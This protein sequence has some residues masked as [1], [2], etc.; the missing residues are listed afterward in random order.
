MRA[1]VRTCLAVLAVAFFSVG[2]GGSGGGGGGGGGGN[3]PGSGTISIVS[4]TPT[5]L[6]GCAPTPITING[7]GFNSIGGTTF[8]VVFHAQGGATPFAGGS[9]DTATATG[10]VT[11]ATTMTVVVPPVVICDG[12]S[13]LT[14]TFDV[15]LESGVAASGSGSVSFT[16]AG[17]A[18]ASISTPTVPAAV[19]TPFVL[20]GTGFGPVGGAVTIRLTADGGATIFKDGTKPFADVQG[21]VASTTTI[22]GVTPI[23]TVCGAASAGCSVKLLFPDG[24]CT[25]TTA[26]GF[27]TFLAPTVTGFSTATLKAAVSDP[28]FVVNGTGFG[29]DGSVAQV[30]FVADGGL[31]LFHDATTPTVVVPG[32]VSGGGT[33]ITCASPLAA[34]CGAATRTASVQVVTAYGSSCAASAPGTLTFTAPTITGAAVG[35]PA[36]GSAPAQIDVTG[37][38]FGP[39]GAPTVV[40]FIADGGA[41]MFEDGTS[42]TIDVPAVVFSATAVRLTTPLVTV[43]GAANRKA[44]LRVFSPYGGACVDTG[45]SYVQFDGPTLALNGFAPNPILST[46]PATFT[47][48]GTNFGP[49]GSAASVRFVA[50][51]GATPFGNGSLS[52][53]TVVGTVASATQITGVAPTVAACGPATS[54]SVVVTLSDGSCVA[55]AAAYV[56]WSGPTLTAPSA[57]S[58]VVVLASAP[59][60][61]I[62]LTG[63]GFAPVGGVA[64][65][66]FV[67]DTAG[68]PLF[69]D[70][71]LFESAAV[72]GTIT[73]STAISVRPP[74]ATVCGATSRLASIRVELANG[75]CAATA[76]Q[77][78][79]YDGPSILTIAAVPPGPFLGGT[80]TPFQISGAGF[81]PVG[82]EAIVRF[83]ASAGAPFANGTAA[84][85]DVAGTV[86]SAS[87][88]TG[89][90]PL[91]ALCGVASVTA[92]FRVTLQDG[93]CADSAANAI[94]W[95]GPTIT[96]VGGVSPFGVPAAVPTV[97]TINGTGFGPVGSAVDVTFVSDAAGPALFGDGTLRESSVVQG[98][99]ASTTQITVRTPHAT[100]CEATSRLASVRIALP[101]GACASSPTGAIRFDAPTLTSL[102]AV[103]AGP[104]VGSVQTGFQLN[105]TNLGSVTTTPA[106]VRFVA[107]SGTPFANGT[108][109]FFDVPGV[110]NAAGTQITGT[111]P[112]VTL[113]G[114]ASVTGSVRVTLQDGTCVDSAASFFTFTGPTVT[115][116]NGVVPAVV[117][118]SSPAPITI[119]GTGF[120]PVGGFADVV[121][122]SDP[123]PEPPL[124]ADGTQ[125]ESAPVLGTI[126]SATTITVTPPNVTVSNAGSRFASVRVRLA[127]GSCAA[128]AAQ[129][130]RFDAPTIT[131]LVATPGPTL[132]A[133][134]P[135]GFTING[136]NFGPG[137]SEAL[138]RFVADGGATPFGNGTLREMTVAGT[139][140][141]GGTQ[142][143]GTTPLLALCPTASMGVAV[144]VMLQDGTS[145]Q[146]GP[147]FATFQAP[148]VTAFAP[149]TFDAAAPSPS[150]FTITGTGFG[151]VGSFVNVR[152]SATGG[153]RPFG[154]GTLPDI[155]VLGQVVSAT[156]VTGTL[157]LATVC[158]VPSVTATVT[159]NLTGGAC[160]STAAGAVTMNGPT[161]AV[162]TPLTPT[163][164]SSTTSSAFT[165]N[166]TGFGPVGQPAFVTFTALA[167]SPFGNGTLVETTVTGTIASATQ[168]TGFAPLA[169][170][171]TGTATARVTVR[172]PNGSCTPVAGAPV[173]T[174]TGPTITA[175][176]PVSVATAGL[177]PVTFTL[178]GTGFAP[179]GPVTVRF[180]S[181]DPIFGDATDLFADVVGTVVNATTITV[182]T[183]LARVCTTTNSA[184]ASARVLFANGSCADSP[185]AVVT[186]NGPTAASVT[187]LPP[188]PALNPGPVTINGTNYPPVGTPVEVVFTAVNG[189]PFATGTDREARVVG[190]VNP[191]G[192]ITVT[193]PL[194]DVCPPLP[195]IAATISLNFGS[196][197]CLTPVPGTVT[198]RAP[199]FT[200]LAVVT[201]AN[202]P[203]SFNITGIDFPVVGTI[204][205]VG[206][207]DNANPGTAFD[208][209]SQ[210]R[211]TVAGVVSALNTIT[212]PNPPRPAAC[213]AD[214][215]SSVD[216]TFG[217]FSCDYPVGGTVTFLAPTITSISQPTIATLT[218][219]NLVITGTNFGPTGVQ[220]LV[221]WQSADLIFADGNQ[222]AIDLPGTV[223]SNTTIAT[224]AP[225]ARIC[226]NTTSTAT[227]RV[228]FPQGS[229]ADSPNPF[230]TFP[231]PTFTANTPS[232]AALN[233]GSLTITGANFPPVGTPVTVHLVVTGTPTNPRIFGSGTDVETFAYGLVG[234]ANSVTVSLPTGS[235]CPPDAA[236]T[237]AARVT[238]ANGSCAEA[239]AATVTYN[240][241]TI[242]SIG[243]VTRDATEPANL[244][245]NGT[246]FPPVNTQVVVRFTAGAAYPQLFGNAGLTQ[247]VVG[248][249]TAA[250]SITVRPPAAAVCELT[251][252]TASLDVNFGND[253]CYYAVP[254]SF[255]YQGPAI[256]T[257]SPNTITALTPAAVTLT[258]VRFGPTVPAGTQ[259]TV[260]WTSADPIFG[261]GTL[262]SVDLPG[263]IASSTSIT[264][265]API[266]RVCAG[267]SSDASIRVIFPMGAC[268]T[269][270]SGSAGGGVTFQG[271]VVT[272]LAATVDAL[273]PGS[274][275]VTGTNFPPVGTPISVTLTAPAGQRPFASGTQNQATV[276][277]QVSPANTIAVV[278]PI[279]DVP[280]VSMVM[281]VGLDIGN[282]TCPSA[283]A[284]TVTYLAPVVA[285]I[286]APLLRDATAPASLNVTGT[287]FPAAGA[288]AEVRFTSTLPIFG[289]TSQTQTV[290]GTV[291]GAGTLTVTPPA[292]AVCE[293]A[294]A[295]ATLAVRFLG[296]SLF[297]AV[298]GTL[299]YQAPAVSSI[300]PA[301]VNAMTPQALTITGVRF[302][303]TAAPT[304]QV[305]VRWT[306]ADPIFGDGTLTSVDLPGTITAATT[307]T[308]TSPLA[309]VC[310]GATSTATF[311]LIF[312]SGA[313]ADSGATTVSFVGPSVAAALAA[314]VNAQDPGTVTV[315]LNNAPPAGTPIA[316]TLTAAGGAR[317][318]AAGTQNQAQVT[319][320][321]GG[322]GVISI[323]LPIAD[324]CTPGSSNLV[325]VGLDIGNSTCPSTPAGTVTYNAPT[326]TSIGAVTTA[327]RA[328]PATLAIAGTNLPADGSN[329][330]VRFLAAGGATPF[331]DG[332]QAQAVVA[333][334]VS[335]GGTTI[336]VVPPVGTV[337]GGNVAT[338]VEVVLRNGPCAYA[339][340]GTLTYLAPTLASLAPTTVDALA[341]VGITLTG[342]NLPPNAT[343]TVRFVA[344]A[345]T[346]FE[347]GTSAQAETTGVVNGAGTSITVANVPGAT[348]CQVAPTVS[349]NVT[350]ILADGCVVTP[351]TNTLTYTRPTITTLAPNTLR[352]RFTNGLAVLSGTNFGGL[353]VN[354]PVQVRWASNSNIF[355]GGTSNV[356][357]TTGLTL[358]GSTIST[359]V[360]DATIC[361]VA[362]VQASVTVFF[363]D[364]TCAGN[365]NVLTYT[366]P[367]VA[368]A[369][370]TG[371]QPQNLS[372]EGQTPFTFLATAG[373]ND[374]SNLVGQTVQ[375]EFSVAAGTP[376]RGGTSA[377]DVVP[378]TV[379]SATTVTGS[380]PTIVAAGNTVPN[381]SVRVRFED[382]TCTD[383][384][385]TSYFRADNLLAVSGTGGLTLIATSAANPYGAGANTIVGGTPIPGAAAPPGG[386]VVAPELNRAF[387]VAGTNLV[388]VDLGG[389]AATSAAG[390]P[391]LGAASIV[392]TVPLGGAGAAA[393]YDSVTARVF[394]VVGNAVVTVDAR[395]ATVL[396]T[397]A[398]PAPALA[399]TAVLDPVNR[400]LLM[401]AGTVIKRFDVDALQNDTQSPLIAAVG[402]AVWT[403]GFAIHPNGGRVV[404][405]YDD[406][407]V[408]NADFVQALDSVDLTTVQWTT[409]LAANS[410]PT[411]VIGVDSTNNAVWW[412]QAAPA[413]NLQLATLAGGVLVAASAVPGASSIVG[414]GSTAN[415][416]YV[417]SAA[418][419]AV[420]VITSG[421]GAIVAGPIAVAG[422]A[423]AFTTSP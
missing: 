153:A 227:I 346:L 65:V 215:V 306:S 265:T 37:A 17:P 292:A 233:P 401:G 419:N 122:V 311:R 33:A 40:R 203:T 274:V 112:L 197:R 297:Y 61:S 48:T 39:V 59:Q 190:F 38:D 411:A 102:A 85:F 394:V 246:N 403:G 138:V 421:T 241:P 284:G 258:G 338:S 375:V 130:I 383:L 64:R 331:A 406:P 123:A 240:A 193:P 57:G 367:Q 332:T 60:A 235:L 142:I 335:G 87:T 161:F 280:P 337:C 318:F 160:A 400:T 354:T 340:G 115:N 262:T 357:E 261:D 402:T 380:A 120:G 356:F 174:F 116:V 329:V 15:L 229:C 166:G 353:A 336:S 100:V 22:T 277:T 295:D 181:A 81:G 96:N 315:T 259:V 223:T 302:G 159:V 187:G 162:A 251:T 98:T 271:P 312:A 230:V 263:T 390:A 388:V 254:G 252:A 343:V 106:T 24:C 245:I 66:V 307:I 363:P 255:T 389:P 224:V 248:T 126:T 212:V 52:E 294:T 147:T 200:P 236:V 148:T 347:A 41:L 47:L 213:P 67:S 144:R 208:N 198:Y 301:T 34:V 342:T 94:T 369:G 237:V 171:C 177:T 202:Q 27:L 92:S 345:G 129:V 360:P 2:C 78:V 132:D 361:G 164:V 244:T 379:A 316:V 11:S 111:T 68:P 413:N 53:V 188:I 70:G 372:Y 146:T 221:R 194:A 86:T 23:A 46:N 279:G 216:V 391:T 417:T 276:V 95:T 152:F 110:V 127:G 378:G 309:R 267:T 270:G 405:T 165:I 185:G 62:T 351:T 26:N 88:I 107:A 5:A 91:V 269:T 355:A 310:A 184:T 141:A 173:M 370:V 125:R 250:T 175:T 93:S 278:L 366:A 137:G 364:G 54:A 101:G 348:S 124:F 131:N 290:V 104:F 222:A 10:L 228:V 136:T 79:R 282:S 117:P 330:E 293:L 83:R 3:N 382:G 313:C 71:T 344:A 268:A 288:T 308:T 25:T 226:P 35:S 305:T 21:I 358:G 205:T 73:S 283:A 149:A 43:C 275:N 243:A 272:A 156:S 322:G 99:I 154:G 314:S 45:A 158:G 134:V 180:T 14:V 195:T 415:T 352:A 58:P 410:N 281:N 103:P 317:I 143:T 381:V 176:S 408:A 287:S 319:A 220:V 16:V 303:P 365:T 423:D 155:I 285:T 420:T 172:L 51:G 32:T 72:V 191:L 49:V 324:L 286:G 416:T 296:N 150:T 169:A 395:T 385:T 196:S 82:S 128:S 133:A 30:R 56:S 333:G 234:P 253:P 204:V 7:T 12:P 183:P 299:R 377:F 349:A 69:G 170:V 9:S 407:N 404:L 210:K 145:I 409:A 396:S 239:T 77:S 31:A 218:P 18:L 247:A 74:H 289:G 118:S 242:T 199:V 20:N 217:N 422:A 13:P 108:S 178:T 323:P 157:P 328:T 121:F 300:A 50:D 339:V 368:G 398:I 334:V 192:Q 135:T 140:N 291:T 90:T 29:A 89:T 189:T 371:F 113:C 75:S 1:F 362:S 359:E 264:T 19:A 397:V 399:G 384:G 119:N 298:P 167:G 63:T 8:R 139:V 376:F 387:G 257:V 114:V 374:F 80:P 76:A 201:P 325:A 273:N 163:N 231:G 232:V 393:A 44:G 260:R 168:I 6:V 182:Q 320:S 304:T 386:V 179:T 350:V 326:F 418:N 341:P 84:E 207:S 321:V 211:T 151:P 373:N 42:A 109:S 327:A 186:F 238:F 209:A 97:V 219:A 105:G 392:A 266:A 55:S 249:V 412:G 225:L 256:T 214:V 36:P 206:F 28:A 4:T 414:P